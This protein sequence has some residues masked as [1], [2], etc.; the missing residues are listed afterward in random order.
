M[1]DWD[2]ILQKEGT[3]EAMPMKPQV[4]GYQLSK[5]TKENALIVSDSGTNTTVW[6]VI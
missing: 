1:K 6:G 4:V 5:H 3:S 2:A